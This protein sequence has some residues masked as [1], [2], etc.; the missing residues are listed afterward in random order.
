MNKDDQQQTGG[1]AGVTHARAGGPHHSLSDDMIRNV[2][3]PVVLETNDDPTLVDTSTMEGGLEEVRV[4]PFRK[5]SPSLPHSTSDTPTV[6]EPEQDGFS[7]QSY[8]GEPYFF[9]S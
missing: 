6:P 8:Y 2:G 9:G 1:I 4:L 3:D 7:A 5:L